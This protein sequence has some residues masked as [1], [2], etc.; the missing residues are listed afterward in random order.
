MDIGSSA[1]VDSELQHTAFCDKRLNTRLLLIAKQ[2]ASQFGKNVASSFSSWKDTKAAYRFFSNA[3][4]T[5]KDLLFSHTTETLTRVRAHDRV[6]F[7]QDTTYIDYKNRPKTEGLD[8]TNGNKKNSEDTTG[9]MLHN[10]LAL[11]I[12]GI[13]LGLINQSYIDR[14]Q[15]QEGTRKGKRHRRHLNNNVSEKESQRWITEV[16]E[17]Q[18]LDVGNTEVIHIADRECDFYEFFRDASALGAHVLIRAA[19]NRSINKDNRRAKP[20]AHLFDYLKNKRAQG[21][22]TINLQINEQNKYRQAT[23]SVIYSPISMPPPP[24]RTR[25]KDGELPLLEL[26]SVMAIER[27]PP[28]GCDALCWVLLTDLPITTLDE[29]IEKIQWYTLRWNIELFH[30]VLKSGCAVE[31]AQL[32]HAERLKKYIAV[33]SIIAW[34]LFWLSRY[35]K[36]DSEANCLVVLTKEEWEILYRKTHKT[37]DLPD[38]PSTISEVF[39]WIAKLGGYIGRR[40]DPPPGMISLWRGWQRLMDMVED[41]RDICG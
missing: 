36:E 11:S 26:F 38:T 40:T 39:I 35:C 13:P 41:Y 32:R 9:L 1:W 22:I 2:L 7:I 31:Q 8:L 21:K 25:S 3:K 6:L 5:I 12:E 34:R 10:T 17:S 15:L 19:R 4:V 30:K 27:N 20:E 37:K 28:K 23:L 14:K 24:S 16:E 29:A 33:K 18:S